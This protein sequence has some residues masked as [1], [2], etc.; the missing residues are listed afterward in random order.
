[1][2]HHNSTDPGLAWHEEDAVNEKSFI[3]KMLYRLI[4]KHIAGTTMSSALAKAKEFNKK[5]M[6]VSVTY[7]S[8]AVES[9]VKARYVT[10]TY[11][12]LIRRI[13]RLGI[14][15]NVQV[16]LEQIGASVSAEAAAENIAEILDAGNRYGVFIWAEVNGEQQ[17]I[18]ER[19]DASKGFGIAVPER[20]LGEYVQKGR[21][22]IIKVMFN[23]E[24]K[25]THTEEKGMPTAVVRLLGKNS[26][27]V[28]S[29][30]PEGML[31]KIVKLGGRYRKSVVF[32]FK[33]GY[34]NKKVAKLMR[35]GV[36]VGIN[37]PFGKDWTGYAMTN[38]PEG[39]MRFL[40]NNLL[41]SHKEKG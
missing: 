26:N 7:L 17:R 2:Q 10:T 28:L 30:P 32:E 19:L 31:W 27:I 6:L 40:A 18:I 38:V 12:E 41:G 1:M 37:V 24:R 25:H 33:M 8:G 13:A 20:H 16:P 4:R 23:D 15:A 34:S 29:S 5:D 22:A 35:K 36:K 11:K 21:R 3:E 39:Y 9:K 14:K